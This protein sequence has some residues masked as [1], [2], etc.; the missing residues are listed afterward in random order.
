[1]SKVLQ[2]AV[3]AIG[4]TPMV[5][6]DRLTADL[7]GTILAKLEYFSPGGSK[8]DRVAKRILEDAEKA[9]LLLP[10]QPVVELTSGNTGAGLAI[11]C[12][13]TGHPF[14]AVLSKGSSAERARMIVALGAEV[15]LVDQLPGSVPGR[16]SG[17]DME[18]VELEARRVTRERGAFRSDQ[19]E[20]QSNVAAHYTGTGQEIW[21]Q[22][23]GRIDAFADFV[24]TGGCLAGVTRAL[25]EHKPSVRCFAV[26]PE[27][28]AVLAGE[29]ASQPN[30]PIQGGGFSRAD[31]THLLDVPIDGY[32]QVTG[33]EA[34]STARL[35]A[36]REGI[37]GGF[38]AG[39]NVAAALH[40]LRNEMAGAT[41]AVLIPDSGLKYLSTDLW[42]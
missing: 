12:A 9:G 35:L 41:I 15:V 36:M 14:V 33:E 19:F 13:V 26:E 20:N 32:V 3:D 34:R 6:L 39:A 30:H 18:L 16:V 37:F 31:L 7:E 22:T 21:E 25:K 4:G 29:A 1:M 5:R 2:S 23:G 27:G 11:A 38:S 10:G 24:G 28:A 17:G 42:E 40:L 8:K